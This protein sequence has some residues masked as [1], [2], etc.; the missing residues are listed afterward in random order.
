MSI[1][2]VG[3]LC[4]KIA[5]RDA[6]RTCVVVEEMSNGYVVVDGD[7]RRKKVNV[8]HLEPLDKTVS[9]KSKASSADVKKAFEKEGLSVWETKA[10]KVAERQKKMKAKK[11][12][13]AVEKK[14]K[15]KKVKKTEE[16]LEAPLEA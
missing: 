14:A 11:E 6:G 13:P 4:V 15:P 2:E 8:R 16:A 9:V 5:G 3:R 1:F 12:A 7:V 10:K